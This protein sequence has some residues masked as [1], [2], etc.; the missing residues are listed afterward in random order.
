MIEC[1]VPKTMTEDH[2]RGRDRQWSDAIFV[3]A[4]EAGDGVTSTADVTERVG[5]SHD[6]AYKRLTTLEDE[7]QLT[8]DRVGNIL[9]WE[10]TDQ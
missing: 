9:I 6:T 7:G 5:C 1:M 10:V 4:V 3:E 2:N 8:S